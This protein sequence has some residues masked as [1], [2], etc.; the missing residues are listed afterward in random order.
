M[1]GQ[2]G[3][4]QDR[5][6]LALNAFRMP[7]TPRTRLRVVSG[8]HS[9]ALRALRYHLR[10]DLLRYILDMVKQIQQVTISAYYGCIAR[11]PVALNEDPS[12]ILHIVSLDLHSVTQSSSSGNLQRA[13]QVAD[14]VGKRII[15]I[16][17]K[18]IEH[19]LPCRSGL[20]YQGGG[21]IAL[22][23]V[24][25]VQSRPRIQK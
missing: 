10:L 2:L 23:G 14:A 9:G 5:A 15:G 3:S 8:R 1:V 25:N 12:R 21:D 24:D 22:I 11:T 17:R 20:V 16:I 4:D 18:N 13:E 6:D 7:L 19:P